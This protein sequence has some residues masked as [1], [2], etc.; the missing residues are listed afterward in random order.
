ML[1]SLS[2]PTPSLPELRRFEN[3]NLFLNFS[4]FETFCSRTPGMMYLRQ[5]GTRPRRAF[6][7]ADMRNFEIFSRFTFP[8][9]A[10]CHQSQGRLYRLPYYSLE[11]APLKEV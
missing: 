6:D 9:G 2:S 7:P 8:A 1:P 5:L 3:S 4:Y 10:W 11:L